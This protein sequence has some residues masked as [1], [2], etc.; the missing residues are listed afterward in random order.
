MKKKIE[1]ILLVLVI[2]FIA[3]CGK[4]SVENESNKYNFYQKNLKQLAKKFPSFYSF[5]VIISNES[6]KLVKEAEKIE[7]QIKKAE[8]IAEA[9]KVFSDSKL[10]GQLNSFDGRYESIKKKKTELGSRRSK[11]YQATIA[12]TISKANQALIDASDIMKNAKPADMEAAVAEVKK[13]NGKLI[14]AEYK[15]N[16]AMRQTKPKTTSPFKKRKKK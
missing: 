11:Q 10:Y 13:A 14:D 7:D 2:V 16:S 15:L 1:S 12:N 5:L 3:G 9:N 4:P 6:Y 8:K